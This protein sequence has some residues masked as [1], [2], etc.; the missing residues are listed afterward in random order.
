MIKP[1]LFGGT[2]DGISHRMREMLL[3]AGCHAK[4]L[5]SVLSVEWHDTFHRGTGMGQ[6]AGLVENHSVS[7]A[8]LF[9]KFSALNRDFVAACLPHG[10]ENAQRHGELQCTGEVHHQHR[11]GARCVAGKQQGQQA[12]AQTPGHQPI[13]QVVRAPLRAGLQFLGLLNHAYDTVIAVLSGRTGHPHDTVSFLHDAACVNGR[14]GSLG[15]GYRFSGQGGLVEHDVPVLEDAVEREHMPGV[16]NDPVARADLRKRNEDLRA[17]IAELPDLIHLQGHASGQIIHGFLV[18]PF[19][20]GLAELQQETHRTCRREVSRQQRNTERNAVEH[21]HRQFSAQQRFCSAPDPR[22]SMTGVEHAPHRGRQIKLF[23]IMPQ[24]LKNKLFLVGAVHG[25]ALTACNLNLRC[26]EVVRKV[27]KLLVECFPAPAEDNDDAA[28]P[29]MHRH[30]I[31]FRQCKQPGLQDVGLLHAHG[32]LHGAQAHTAA[33][34]M[35]YLESHLTLSPC[36]R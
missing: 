24:H 16:D 31:D 22:Q 11:Y 10:R 32:R 26:R 21:I 5:F 6:R 33:A 12:A 29:F 35:Q 14:A 23:Q 13:G 19:V 34:L 25:A 4:H 30:L 8:E 18:C 17:I 7:F 27:R 28:D 9:Q 20:N 36:P 15:D 1:S 2:H 3:Q